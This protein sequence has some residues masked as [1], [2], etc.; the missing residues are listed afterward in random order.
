[1]DSLKPYRK[2]KK[3]IK[4]EIKCVKTKVFRVVIYFIAGVGKNKGTS[5][6]ERFPDFAY[7]Y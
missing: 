4:Y 3:E 5:A 7:L 1:V 6:F 2:E